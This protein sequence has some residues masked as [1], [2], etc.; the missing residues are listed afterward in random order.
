[1]C[2]PDSVQLTPSGTKTHKN[3][4]PNTKAS[5]FQT[6]LNR[7]QNLISREL[8]IQKSHREGQYHLLSKQKKK[9]DIRR[10]ANPT[11][12]YALSHGGYRLKYRVAW[13]RTWGRTDVTVN[14]CQSALWSIRIAA[15]TQRMGPHTLRVKLCVTPLHWSWVRS[16]LLFRRSVLAGNS[17]AD[18]VCREAEGHCY[19]TTQHHVHSGSHS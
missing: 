11:L 13:R 17:V 8:L 18:T 19:V 2:R 10:G 5:N 9:T 16:L 15:S 4:L 6:W 3:V 14:W 7:A 12:T 1:M